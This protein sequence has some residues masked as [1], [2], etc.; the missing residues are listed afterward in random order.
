MIQT[1]KAGLGY[2]GIVF[3]VGFVL[4]AI[5]IVLVVPR[6]GARTAELL[7]TPFMLVISFLAARWVVRGQAV[8]LTTPKRLGMGMLALALM[9]AAEFGFVL[10]LRGISLSQYFATRDPISGTAYYIALVIFALM[11]VFVARK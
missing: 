9:L 11:P 4:G 3:T 2:F 1:L 10:W 8:P 6:F 7:E 5:R